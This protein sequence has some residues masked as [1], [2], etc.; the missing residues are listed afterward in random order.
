M[1]E[2]SAPFGIKKSDKTLTHNE[3][4]RAIRFSIASEYEAIQIYE[5]IAE[6][7]SDEN[8]KKILNE[9]A[10][11]ERVHVGNLSYLLSLISP[12]DKKSLQEG[13]DE[14]IEILNE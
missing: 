3:L 6:S 11:D 1:P 2:F 4:I 8:S 10:E 13:I 7:I 12:E 9:I 14:A 5:E